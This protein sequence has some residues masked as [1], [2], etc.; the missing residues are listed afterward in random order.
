MG[1]V[2]TLSYTEI[3]VLKRNNFI[4][5]QLRYPLL[6]IGSEEDIATDSSTGL[7]DSDDD[8]DRSFNVSGDDDDIEDH[9]IK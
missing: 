2:R 3:N 8:S 4:K 6:I 7:E 9:I 5:S 1:S